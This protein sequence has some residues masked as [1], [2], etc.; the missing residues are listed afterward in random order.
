MKNDENHLYA[1]FLELHNFSFGEFFQSTLL[2]CFVALFQ[3]CKWNTTT[4]HLQ[5]QKESIPVC[6]I[7]RA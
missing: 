1:I 2:H 4:S 5:P 3:D 6:S 7:I